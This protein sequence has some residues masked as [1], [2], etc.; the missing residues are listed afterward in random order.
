MEGA[1]VPMDIPA[2]PQ[3][4][5]VGPEPEPGPASVPVAV[6]VP[7]SEPEPEPEPEPLPL[8]PEPKPELKPAKAEPKPKPKPKPVEAKP[9]PAKAEA[10]PKAVEALKPTTPVKPAKTG[11][12][13][14]GATQP[15]GPVVPPRADASHR[16][17]P[18]PTY[19]SQSRRMREEGKV[20]LDVHILEDGRVG[21]IRLRRSS[22]FSRLDQ[23][24]LSAVKRWRYIPARQGGKAIAFWY[25]QPVQF[26]L[27]E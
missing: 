16:N 8:K 5:P 2:P 27:K 13:G 19:P 24:A 3:P 22:G 25:V 6:P 21:E 23:A 18:P 20:L 11:K 10:K 26:T 4:L 15:S 1:L 17:N 9:K 14:G 7:E 12:A